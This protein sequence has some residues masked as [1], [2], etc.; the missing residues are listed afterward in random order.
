MER[1]KSPASDVVAA[2]QQAAR[3]VPAHLGDD[4]FI[5]LA[6]RAVALGREP[7]CWH[8]QRIDFVVNVVADPDKEFARKG[9]K[10]E[11]GGVF[12]VRHQS[13]ERVF[14]DGAWRSF[15]VLKRRD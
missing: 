9:L 3:H 7:A 2:V 10:G 15:V 13:Q 5:E 11:P 12:E 1:D 6:A 8:D 4:V 14:V